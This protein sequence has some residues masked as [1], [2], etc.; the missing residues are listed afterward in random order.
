MTNYTVIVNG[1]SYDVFVEKKKVNTANIIN[2]APVSA[3]AP[4]PIIKSVSKAGGG[5]ENVSAPMPGKIIE[6]RV[7]EGDSV[8]KGQELLIME[9]MKMHNPI[10]APSD[11]MISKLF[12]KVNESVQTGQPILSIK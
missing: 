9:A 10:L 6:I 8:K 4:M 2:A 5:G 12:V 3:P 1:K 7:R 11:G